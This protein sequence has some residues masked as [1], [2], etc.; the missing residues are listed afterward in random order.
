MTQPLP[1]ETYGEPATALD[2]RN[3]DTTLAAT[4]YDL[5]A[6]AECQLGNGRNAPAGTTNFGFSD[7][8]YTPTTAQVLRQTTTSQY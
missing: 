6:G 8:T 5:G 2:Y 3:A 4:G 7:T 1:P